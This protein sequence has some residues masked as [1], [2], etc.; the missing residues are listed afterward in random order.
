MDGQIRIFINRSMLVARVCLSKSRQLQHW[1]PTVYKA[2][3]IIINSDE[4]KRRIP[5]QVKLPFLTL[6][7]KAKERCL[8]DHCNIV[9]FLI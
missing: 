1:L 3:C 7:K 4:R 8:L 2:R 5:K 9:S 6:K